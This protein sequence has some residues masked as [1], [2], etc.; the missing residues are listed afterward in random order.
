L[1]ISRFPSDVASIFAVQTCARRHWAASA[2]GGR[3]RGETDQ[4]VIDQVEQAVSGDV[5][6]P[7]TLGIT[8]RARLPEP[9]VH[10]IIA[11]HDG[12]GR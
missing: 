12:D 3:Q 5:S 7:T 10:W 9:K 11:R 2:P 6:D 4:I 8:H 1:V